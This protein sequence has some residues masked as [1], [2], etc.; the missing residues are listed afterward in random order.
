MEQ[1]AELYLKNGTDV[2]IAIG[3]GSSMDT[4]KGIAIIASNGGK[5]RDYE[6]ANLISASY[7]FTAFSR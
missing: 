3:G 7:L 6:G 1:G 2:I 4:A 5:I